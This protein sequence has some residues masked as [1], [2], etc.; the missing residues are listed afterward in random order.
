MSIAG[1]LTF[2]AAAVVATSC[3]SKQETPA[4]P[5]E[6]PV[7]GLTCDAGL[8]KTVSNLDGF[9]RR[10]IDDAALG[11]AY[12]SVADLNGDGRKDL[13]IS[14]FDTFAR[15]GDVFRIKP[16]RI[17]AYYQGPSGV[18]C[19][20]K[21]E[22]V[23]A[24]EE[25]YFPNQTTVTDVD[26]DG[27]LDVIYTAGFF[28][29][30][31]DPSVRRCGLIGWFE[32]TGGAWKRHDLVPV[33]QGFYHKAL[34]VDVDGDGTKD[35]ISVAESQVKAR[36]FKGD[37]SLPEKFQKTPLEMG[38]FGGSL[39]ILHDVDGD[40]DL[41]VVS[42]EFYVQGGSF[43]WL[44][45][46]AP[47]SASTPAGTWARHVIAPATETGKGFSIDAIPN[48][49]GDGKVRFVGTNHTNTQLAENPDTVESAVFTFEIP[50]D[51]KQP[52]IR[53]SISTGIVS[54]SRVG[55]GAPGVF[56]W[57]DLDG[58]GDIDLA[59][60]GDGD[61]RTF[62]IEQTA[63]GK[64]ETRVIDP[65]NGQAGGGLILDLDGDGKAEIVF[66]GYEKN[67]VF[68]YSKTR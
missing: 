53:T 17:T 51:P 2:V 21:Q 3:S 12:V 59:V 67:S 32:N 61:Q 56:G 49:F 47:P 16:G 33:S 13:I 1:K 14:S 44:E 36:W 66:T 28:V 8:G 45:K 68:V 11:A 64:F 37:A 15:D 23:S 63:P 57:G 52:W 54:R 25:I 5:A 24:A 50:T 29:C 27:D 20:Q 46:V 10:T 22:I 9:S 38:E 60:S 41:D 6:S 40:G 43:A 7:L 34:F 65:D 39:P 58:D 18:D 55:Q 62:L 48:L 19:W 42:S 4:K 26:G 31:L 30:G 35:L